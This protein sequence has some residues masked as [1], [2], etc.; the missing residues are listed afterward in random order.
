MRYKVDKTRVGQATDLDKLSVTVDTDGTITPRDAFEEAAAI[1]VNQYS[2]LAGKTR[3]QAQDTATAP[4]DNGDI[5]GDDGSMLST[6][7]EEFEP[8][9]PHHE[10]TGEQ[11][12]P[13]H[14]GLLCLK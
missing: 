9:R 10:R 11:R 7:I 8:N 2:A 4:S 1:L 3:V 12:H 5:S 6:S 14:S 13:H